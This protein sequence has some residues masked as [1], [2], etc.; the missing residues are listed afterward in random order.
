MTD[1]FKGERKE[2]RISM[3]KL[4]NL[5]WEFNTA[6]HYERVSSEK[7]PEL[8]EEGE[9]KT[10]TSFEEYVDDH[11]IVV[12]IKEDAST[13]YFDVQKDSDVHPSWE[14]WATGD[15]EQTIKDLIIE[16][17][18]LEVDDKWLPKINFLSDEKTANAVRLALISDSGF[19]DDI[20]R[21]FH[22]FPV[23]KTTIYCKRKSSI[24][25][26]LNI[27]S[28]RSAFFNYL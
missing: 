14:P 7:N 6:Q 28:V 16:R 19:Y 18:Y 23:V 21:D 11:D 22:G 5:G 8:V 27:P 9:V 17:F 15:D 26:L 4:V 13:W 1:L 20:I 25:D 10:Y 3:R 12:L 2:V 24:D